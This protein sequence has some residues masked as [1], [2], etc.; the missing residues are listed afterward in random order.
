MMMRLFSS[1]GSSLALV[2]ALALGG[3]SSNNGNPVDSGTGTDTGT[4]APAAVKVTVS[5]TASPHRLTPR[6]DPTA[7]FTQ[8][9]VAVVD[10]MTVIAHPLDP[11]LAGGPLDTTAANCPAATGCAWS[12]D[13]VDISKITLGL[14]GIVDDARP[15]GSRKWVK[16]GTGAGASSFILMVQQNPVPITNRVLFAVSKASEGA[17]ATFAAAFGPDST[18]APGVLETRGFMLASIVG[19]LSEGA[20]PVAGAT[21]TTNDTRT[22]IIYPNADFSGVGTSTAVH[23]TVLVVPKAPGDSGM[24]SS[25]VASWHITPPSGDARAWPD[26]TAGTSPGA[27]FVLLFAANE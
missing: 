22:N 11:P 8:M 3:C 23:G 16:T 1:L 17:L 27:A 6:L 25:I 9:L 13:N 20:M 5:G 7:D 26:L 12:F 21:I 10:P 2:G 18:V 24:T 15:A 4:D 19:K 14:V